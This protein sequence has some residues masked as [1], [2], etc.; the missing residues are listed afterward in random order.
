MTRE[1]QKLFNIGKEIVG[2]SKSATFRI[3]SVL[4]T[5]NEYYSG[6]NM[7]IV[8]NQIGELRLKYYDKICNFK[9]ELPNKPL[10]KEKIQYNDELEKNLKEM[11]GLTE[12]SKK[13]TDIL[14]DE[15]KISI[16]LKQNTPK[17]TNEIM[18]A[19]QFKQMMLCVCGSIEGFI[20]SKK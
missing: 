17:K 9:L 20:A 18:E 16:G 6:V 13:L 19:K 5:L 7:I 10:D 14:S 12:T 4:R 1:Y 15:R 2:T 3:E 11:E 8:D